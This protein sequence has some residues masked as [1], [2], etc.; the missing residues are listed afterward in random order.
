LIGE[1]DD[2]MTVL[3]IF[4]DKHKH[5]HRITQSYAINKDILNIKSI[6]FIR[7]KEKDNDTNNDYIIPIEEFKTKPTYKANDFELQLLMPLEDLK[8]FKM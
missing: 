5:L 2:D 6:Q 4:R 7:L 3:T 8:E 1:L